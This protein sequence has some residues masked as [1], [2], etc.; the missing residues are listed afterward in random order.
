MKGAGV[1]VVMKCVCL[2]GERERERVIQEAPCLS[3]YIGDGIVYID[4]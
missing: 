4:L 1:A 3:V 2:W